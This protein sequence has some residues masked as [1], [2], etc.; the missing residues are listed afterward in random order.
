MLTTFQFSVT[1]WHKAISL[2]VRIYDC[3]DF[4][5]RRA[6]HLVPPHA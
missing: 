1:I 3:S 4:K 2:L 6:I 5:M